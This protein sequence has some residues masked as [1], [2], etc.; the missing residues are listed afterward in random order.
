MLAIQFL[1]FVTF[2]NPCRNI[3]HQSTLH[4]APLGRFSNIL[5]TGV[6]GCLPWY[7]QLFFYYQFQ[8]LH[9]T[10]IIINCPDPDRASN[11]RKLIFE[12][13]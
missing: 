13:C 4:S 5:A 3:I 6:A 7:E 1:E 12:A 11:L 2:S 8:V 9:Q 10:V